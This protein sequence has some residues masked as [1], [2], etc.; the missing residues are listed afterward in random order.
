MRL[1]FAVLVLFVQDSDSNR[2]SSAVN[3]GKPNSRAH[4]SRIDCQLD[5]SCLTCK[6]PVDCELGERVQP[7]MRVS[8]IAGSRHQKTMIVCHSQIAPQLVPSSY[9]PS[10][11]CNWSSGISWA[12]A[13]FLSVT[14]GGFGADRFYLGLWKSAIG[15]LFSFGGLGI[16]TIIDVVLI[17][18]G[19][20]RPA[21]GSLYI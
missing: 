2:L 18:T 4:C 3:G 9:S 8:D 20:I 7:T 19:Y 11:R 15:K 13:M 5:A 6:F 12:K 17:A 21:D 14:L 16:W 10:V 1:A